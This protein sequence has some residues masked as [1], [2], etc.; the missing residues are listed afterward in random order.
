MRLCV[1]F[2]AAHIGNT[3]NEFSDLLVSGILIRLSAAVSR[4]FAVSG[5]WARFGYFS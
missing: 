4:R 5:G 1:S 2:K 3:H